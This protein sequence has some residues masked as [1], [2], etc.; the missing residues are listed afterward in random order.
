VNVRPVRLVVLFAWLVGAFVVPV[1]ASAQTSERTTVTVNES[2]GS[3][4]AWVSTSPTPT[5]LSVEAYFNRNTGAKSVEVSIFRNSKFSGSCYVENP[6][7][8]IEYALR[9]ASLTVSCRTQNSFDYFPNI[10]TMAVQVTWTGVGAT[11]KTLMRDRYYDGDDLI[12]RDLLSGTKNATVSAVA[13]VNGTT[14]IQKNNLK[15]SLSFLRGTITT[16]SSN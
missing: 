7:F 3:L 5:N 10:Y 13:K 2:F 15:G 1:T 8:K 14:Y 9:W 6:N 11:E 16:V 12:I 4:N